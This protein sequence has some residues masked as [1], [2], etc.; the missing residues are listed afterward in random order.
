MPLYA[1]LVALLRA[2]LPEFFG[3]LSAAL[4]VAA[5]G[6]TV[7]WV[8]ESRRAEQPTGHRTD[9]EVAGPTTPP[10]HHTP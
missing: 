3:S 10:E 4:V 6:W 8:R 9:T 5:G 1:E 2:T 7:R